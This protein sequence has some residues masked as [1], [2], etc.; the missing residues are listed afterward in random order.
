M[1]EKSGFYKSFLVRMWREGHEGEWRASIKDV[2]TSESYNFP[3]V[4]AL[5]QFLAVETKPRT[6]INDRLGEVYMD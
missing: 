4:T 6:A 1:K 5:M 3:N 2:G